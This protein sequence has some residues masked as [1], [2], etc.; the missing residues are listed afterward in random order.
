MLA[1]LSIQSQASC[2]IKEKILMFDKC[3]IFFFYVDVKY[4]EIMYMVERK[5][6]KKPATKYRIYKLIFLI[7]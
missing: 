3:F 7:W 5:K 2:L 4:L 6:S 1:I